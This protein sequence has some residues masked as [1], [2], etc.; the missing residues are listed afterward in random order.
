ALHYEASALHSLTDLFA[1]GHVVT[2]RDESSYGIVNDAALTQAPAYQWMENAIGVGGGLRATDGVVNLAIPLPA[3]TAGANPR[4]A[5]LL[6]YQK[7]WGRWSLNEHTYHDTFNLSGAQ[8]RNLNGDAFSILGDSMLHRSWGPN[9]GALFAVDAVR[10]SVQSLF[11]AY[12][13]LER[14]ATVAQVG[15]AGSPFYAALK[16]VPVFIDYDPH[17]YFWGRWT[18][19]AKFVDQVTGAGKVPDDW[20]GCAIPRLNGKSIWW[21][22]VATGACTTGPAPPAPR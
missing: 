8:V 5:L 14:G 2:N 20:A 6:T 17:K 7:G 12:Q 3:I 1:F 22:S 15:R 4:D 13:A 18:L 16:V 10:A 9:Q 21:P 19:Y 11:D